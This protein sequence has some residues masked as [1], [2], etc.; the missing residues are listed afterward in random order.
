MTTT[1]AATAHLFDDFRLYE[2]ATLIGAAGEVHTANTYVNE[3]GA[4]EGHHPWTWQCGAD[5]VQ[6]GALARGEWT[7]EHIALTICKTETAAMPEGVIRNDFA[8]ANRFDY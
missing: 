6:W 4:I 8:R 2:V 3:I 1:T 7:A 5:I